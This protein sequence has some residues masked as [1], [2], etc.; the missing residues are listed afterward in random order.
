[1]LSSPEDKAAQAFFRAMNVLAFDPAQFASIFARAELV[2]Q[3][4]A[5]ETLIQWVD[6]MAA[7]F[8]RSDYRSEDELDFLLAAKRAQDAMLPFRERGML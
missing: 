7:R 2:I 6:V 1:V 8:D 5:L 4:R 3:K